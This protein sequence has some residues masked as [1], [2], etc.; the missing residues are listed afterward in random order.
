ML[1]AYLNTHL[2]PHHIVRPQNLAGQ[3][4]VGVCI[5][6]FS[7]LA[8]YSLG[9]ELREVGLRKQGWGVKLL[10]FYFSFLEGRC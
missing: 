8:C 1:G 6:V 3:D 7:P 4:K 9:K 10:S 2:Q 5:L